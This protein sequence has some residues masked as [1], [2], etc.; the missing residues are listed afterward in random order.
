MKERSNLGKFLD[1]KGISQE[2][3]V[4]RTGISRNSISDL[5]DG[6]V[7]NP[8]SVTRSKIIKALREIDPHVSASD[9][10]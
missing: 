6:T 10:W 8:R 3:L 9:F 7:E 2:W 5:C 4:K 1:R